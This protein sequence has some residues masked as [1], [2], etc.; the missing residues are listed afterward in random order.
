[1]AGRQDVDA[2]RTQCDR[3]R[4]RRVVRHAPVHEQTVLPRDGREDARD[5]GAR[6]H[7]L[8]ERAGREQQLLAR[9]HVD[10]HHVQRNG[11]VLD[12]SRAGVARDQPAQPGG[13]D[14]MVAAAQEAQQPGE[15]IEREHAPAAQA[16]PDVRQLVGGGNSLGP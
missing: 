3:V 16:A 4:D 11:E 14:E 1:M 8:V 15:R 5:R 7:S 13:R 9:D 10:R 2:P 12:R 6:E